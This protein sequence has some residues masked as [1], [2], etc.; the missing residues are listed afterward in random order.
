V[1]NTSSSSSLLAQG[2]EKDSHLHFLV[3]ILDLRTRMTERNREEEIWKPL[4]PFSLLHL[5]IYLSIYSITETY[6][7][8]CRYRNAYRYHDKDTDMQGQ[9]PA[10]RSGPSIDTDIDI[11]IDIDMVINAIDTEPQVGDR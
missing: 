7:Y 6:R 1:K 2:K 4:S 11:D 5:Y 9:A 10:A 8:R 3:A